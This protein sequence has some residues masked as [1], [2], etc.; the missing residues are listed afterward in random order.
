LT[1]TT[2]KLR[3]PAVLPFGMAR[4]PSS[5][6]LSKILA[7][8]ALPVCKLNVFFCFFGSATPCASPPPPWPSLFSDYYFRFHHLSCNFYKLNGTQLRGWETRMYVRTTKPDT[9]F[10][11]G[12]ESFHLGGNLVNKFFIWVNTSK[13]YSL[14]KLCNFPWYG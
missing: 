6:R 3:P 5:R 8:S 4:R 13:I 7:S 11:K 2:S 10:V 14:Q 9:K 1:S 12:S